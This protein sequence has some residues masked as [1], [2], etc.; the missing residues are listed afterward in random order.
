L[1][2]TAN[3]P[4][5]E[6]TEVPVMVKRSL[7]LLA[8]LLCVCLAGLAQV[9]GK[10]QIHFIDVGQGDGAVLI[11]P[12]GEVAL[13]DDGALKNCDKPI[14]YL[15]Q[16]GIKKIRYQFTSHYHS[17][18]IGCATQVFTEIGT[19]EVV[20]DRGQSYPSS[21]YT[22]YA[23]ALKNRRNTP[24]KGFKVTLDADG[25][26]P[27]VI[28]IVS[29][30]GNGVTTDNENDLS[31]AAVVRYGDFAAE[32]GGDLSGYDTDTYKDI[33][34]SVAP[35][36]KKIQVY[37]VHHHCSRYS[38]NEN[39]LSATAPEIGIVSVG[40]RNVYNHPAAEC[41][42]RLHQHGVKTYW[43]E[44][45]NGADPDAAYDTV[46]GNIIVEVAPGATSFTVS[47]SLKLLATYQFSV[48]EG[49][50]PPSP[51]VDEFAWSKNSSVYHLASCKY[52]D[53]ISATNLQRGTTPPAGKTLHK[54]CP[55]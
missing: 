47:N 53:N 49:S 39:W 11:S 48:A 14:S 36:V 5:A 29:I 46:A 40:D 23:N 45:G 27:V 12:K 22:S 8:A 26:T 28:E 6:I 1:F 30:N 25:A 51:A 52:V 16:L 38:T 43:T 32:I 44:T 20:Y 21:T 18:H 31:L 50:A 10:L 41:L 13:F 42:E 54:G 24:A 55:K 35:S 7:S 15:Q 37:K 33:E 4:K 19:P 9:N 2:L 3:N 17:D 34:T